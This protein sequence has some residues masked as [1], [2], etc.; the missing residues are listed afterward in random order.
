VA[1]TTR[2]FFAALLACALLAAPAHAVHVSCGDTITQNTRLDS[3]LLDCPGDGVVIAA[4]DVTIDFA[5][6]TIDGIRPAPSDDAGVGVRIERQVNRFTL[7][8]GTIREFLCAAMPRQPGLFDR[9]RIVDNTYCGIESGAGGEVRNSFFS[10]NRGAASDG[11]GLVTGSTFVDNGEYAIRTGDED[12]LIVG[13][14]VRRN[15]TGI[16]VE[17]G[18]GTIARNFVIDNPGAGID[19]NRS[20]GGTIRDNFVARNGYGITLRQEVQ[21]NPLIE[22]NLVVANRANGIN[23]FWE[24]NGSLVTHNLVYGNG[25]SG[26]HA[27]GFAPCPD[28]RH[29]YVS[30]NGLSGITVAEA[31]GGGGVELECSGSVLGN[32]ALHNAADGIHVQDMER[33]VVVGRNRAN[34]NGELGIEATDVT[35][36]GGN[37]ARRNGDPRQCVGV[38]CR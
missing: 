6:H 20:G 1:S 35:D 30:R 2:I 25:G 10:G 36:G 27:T 12:A 21:A 32:T 9:M 31:G 18:T 14:V 26:I 19:W 37:R 8:G 13:N 16:I 24:W 28:L 34:R 3:D 33:Q 11:P 38:A 17:E 4:N 7:V 15:P 22:R 29:N 5:G 23:G